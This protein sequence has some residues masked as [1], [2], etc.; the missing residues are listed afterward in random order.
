MEKAE[1]RFQQGQ[2]TPEAVLAFPGLRLCMPRVEVE[3]SVCDLRA[4]SMRGNLGSIQ[5]DGIQARERFVGMVSS[6]SPHFPVLHSL[7]TVVG[8]VI[9]PALKEK[10]F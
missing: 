5:A 10:E 2:T 9:I 7:F 4:I 6:L 3:R 8:E 1:R